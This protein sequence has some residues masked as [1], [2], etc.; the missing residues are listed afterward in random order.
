MK[1]PWIKNGRKWSLYSAILTAMAYSVMSLTS[2]P[3]Y[4]GTCTTAECNGAIQLECQNY[5]RIRGGENR[6]ICPNPG[7]PTDAVCWC[8]DHLFTVFGC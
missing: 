8:N 5:C 7:N 4:A 2:Q 6:L 3:A 1:T